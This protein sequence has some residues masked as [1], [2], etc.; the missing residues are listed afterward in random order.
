MTNAVIRHT[1]NIG[2]VFLLLTYTFVYASFDHLLMLVYH[3]L[4]LHHV[5]KMAEI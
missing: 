5:M 4:Y 2:I 3:I 1:G